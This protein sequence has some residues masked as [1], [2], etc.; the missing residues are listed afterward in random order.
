VAGLSRASGQVA[1]PN[2]DKPISGD[3]G[4]IGIEFQAFAVDQL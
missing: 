4:K 2:R 1:S 3:Q